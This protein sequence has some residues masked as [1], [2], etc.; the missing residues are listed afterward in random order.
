MI[1]IHEVF[2][3]KPGSASKLAQLFKEVT[4][5][6]TEL[7]NIMTDTRWSFKNAHDCAAFL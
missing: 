2:V 5:G 6:S 3:C 4:S 7:V 1:I